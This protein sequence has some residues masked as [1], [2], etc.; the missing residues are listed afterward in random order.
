MTL[1]NGVSDEQ[2]SGLCDPE[3]AISPAHAEVLSRWVSNWLKQHRVVFPGCEV[4][5]AGKIVTLAKEALNL[6]PL[7]TSTASLS[8]P[9]STKPQSQ[10][11]PNNIIDLTQRPEFER[12]VERQSEGDDVPLRQLALF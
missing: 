12:L 1:M 8:Q 6:S 11:R 9:R 5:A 4:E 7:E 10:E 2:V 3:F